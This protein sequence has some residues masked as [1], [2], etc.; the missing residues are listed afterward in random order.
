MLSKVRQ[1]ISFVETSVGVAGKIGL[2]FIIGFFAV[3]GVGALLHPENNITEGSV[4]ITIPTGDHGG[5]G[6]ILSSSLLQTKIL[7]NS[8]VC[9]AIEKGGLVVG[10]AG[11]FLAQSYKHS[12]LHDLCIITVSG[13]M[14]YT[15][16]VSNSPPVAHKEMAS[17]SGHPAL[18]PNVVTTGHFSDRKI[19]R[20]MSGYRPCSEEEMSNPIN[21]FICL[22]TGGMPIVKQYESTLVTATIMPGSSGS[23]V[24]NSYNELVGLAFAGSG[25][26]GYA[27][28][29]PFESL[30]LFLNNEQY[31]IDDTVI[32]NELTVKA[33]KESS[34]EDTS[35]KLLKL[36]C[37]SIDREKIVYFCNI[38]ERNTLWAY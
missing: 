3:Y 33:T 23:G 17:I 9:K 2:G 5:T 7:T 10:K 4:M 12:K 29:V 35:I 19:I 21:A 34:F 18:L 6:V 28:T 26:L 27:Q 20:V 14:R 37:R 8:H 24:Y 16:K 25:S 30:K 11:T 31:T 13:D 15:T 38:V 22:I 36:A 1:L 32:N